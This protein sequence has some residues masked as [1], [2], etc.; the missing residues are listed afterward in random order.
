MDLRSSTTYIFK[1]SAILKPII[2]DLSSRTLHI[3]KFQVILKPISMDL[4]SRTSHI[5]KLYANLKPKINQTNLKLH[6]CSSYM[7]FSKPILLDKCKT[8]NKVLYV[9]TKV[10]SL[11][12]GS[13]V[14]CQN[15]LLLKSV[16]QH[17]AGV[18]LMKCY[19]LQQ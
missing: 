14:C 16:I 19:L 12:M 18:Q 1:F 4:S 6:I 7:P 3:F 9:S 5:L 11:I 8:D 13:F 17:R 10:H 15:F 2:M